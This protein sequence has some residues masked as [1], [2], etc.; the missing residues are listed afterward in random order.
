VVVRIAPGPPDALELAAVI[1]RLAADAPTREAM[2][3]RARRYAQ[4]ELTPA[5]TA[6]GYLRAIDDVLALRADPA[7]GALARWALALRDLGVTPHL[8]ER[9]FGVGFAD[10]LA[11]MRPQ[12]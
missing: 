6:A 2:G 12:G 1:E 4:T 8:A 3:E 5:R 10:A 9:G 11:D 7:R